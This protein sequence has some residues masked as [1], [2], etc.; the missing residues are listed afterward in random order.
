[1]ALCPGTYEEPR[2]LG[3]GEER[4]SAG[5][6]CS[7]TPTPYGGWAAA[8]GAEPGLPA[9]SPTLA[10]PAGASGDNAYLS[11]R[12]RGQR[13]RVCV[14]EKVHIARPAAGT[15]GSLS[16]GPSYF[17]I[18]HLTISVPSCLTNARREHEEITS[19]AA[20]LLPLPPPAPPGSHETFSFSALYLSAKNGGQELLP[21]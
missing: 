17:P 15:G 3:S 12:G 4:L 19:V 13:G 9:S 20:L 2:A 10:P 16:P 6:S 8:R 21:I 1:M 5:R 7:H 18:C 11:D 14:S